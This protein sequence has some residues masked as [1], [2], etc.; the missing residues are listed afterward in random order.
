MLAT[1][2]ACFFS[3]AALAHAQSVTLSGVVLAPPPATIGT[4]A[5]TNGT[6]A[7]SLLTDNFSVEP[8]TAVSKGGPASLRLSVA[9]FHD[10]DTYRDKCAYGFAP[11][12]GAAWA[13]SK[14]VFGVADAYSSCGDPAV[15]IGN[16][17][18]F[19]AGL[20]FGRSQP[21]PCSN[22]SAV[23]IARRLHTA[24]TYDFE[25]S[26]TV[27][28]EASSSLFLD[29][30]WVAASQVSNAVYVSWTQVTGTCTSS[31]IKIA[32]IPDVRAPMKFPPG[33]P[34]KFSPC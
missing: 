21:A 26:I 29:K 33:P 7:T 27:T 34:M 18:A 8:H 13:Q 20:A 24:S 12:F 31:N 15:A 5:A 1:S 17:G 32:R 10:N 19:F 9:A 6:G 28:S 22:D 16:A 25:Q 4:G 11:D 23:V 3:L 2:F 14:K 30:P